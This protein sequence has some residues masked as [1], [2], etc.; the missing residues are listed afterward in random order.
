MKKAPHG[1]FFH[2]LSGIVPPVRFMYS[3]KEHMRSIMPSSVISIMRFA[4]VCV[5]WWSWL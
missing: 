2:Y 3:S 1:C 4:T 5:S